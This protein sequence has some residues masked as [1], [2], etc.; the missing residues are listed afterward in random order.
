MTLKPHVAY[1]YPALLLYSTVL[2]AT[3]ISRVLLLVGLFS[4]KTCNSPDNADCDDD[5]QDSVSQRVALLS[6]WI[7]LAT[8]IPQL[9]VSPYMGRL[10]NRVGRRAPPVVVLLGTMLA[11]MVIA[12]VT[13]AGFSPNWIILAGF[14]E[15]CTGSYS[16]FLIGTSSMTA[17][18]NMLLEVQK[19]RQ[20]SKESPSSATPKAELSSNTDNTQ[21][22]A[23]LE[24]MLALGVVLG[25][26]CGAFVSEALSVE[27][28]VKNFSYFFLGAAVLLGADAVYMISVVPE[29]LHITR[30]LSLRSRGDSIASSSSVAAIRYDPFLLDAAPANESK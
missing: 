3:Y 1:L 25:P 11:N 5:D 22:F 20:K 4:E 17:D 23:Y 18:L 27:E 8:G 10:A 9:L 19:Q 29:T 2:F 14:F 26:L 24:A 6:T 7:G 12:V 16:S 28:N 13:Y 30:A 21:R 15:G